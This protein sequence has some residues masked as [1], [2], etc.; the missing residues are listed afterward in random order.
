[1]RE[2]DAL[3]QIIAGGQATMAKTGST[4]P[5]PAL[6]ESLVADADI[7]IGKPVFYF[8]LPSEG[9]EMRD[10]FQKEGELPINKTLAFVDY[11]YPAGTRKDGKLIVSLTI[12]RPKFRGGVFQKEQVAL[13]TS[14]RVPGEAA[15]FTTADVGVPIGNLS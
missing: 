2:K 9:G 7:Q 14:S 5:R 12:M 10:P 4:G 8:L 1:M 3:T 11:V 6:W 15:I 13:S